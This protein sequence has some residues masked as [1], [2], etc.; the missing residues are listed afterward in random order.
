MKNR[1]VLS[2]MVI[3]LTITGALYTKA[4]AFGGAGL[5]PAV[6]DEDALSGGKLPPRFEALVDVLGLS[7]AQVVQVKAVLAEEMPKT[8][9]LRT[10]LHEARKALRV[11]EV[12][13]VF[14]EA[15]VRIPA[16]QQADAQVELRVHRARVQSRLLALLS[17][18]QQELAKK[19][20]PLFAMEKGPGRGKGMEH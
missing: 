20:R 12:S 4:H 16:R 7:E 18:R 9:P 2:I 1:F 13:S 3:M 15:Q 19:L 6:M 11:L 8:A 14:D 17:P 10:Q 5:P